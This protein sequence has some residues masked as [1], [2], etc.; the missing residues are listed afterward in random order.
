MQTFGR[1]LTSDA[2]SILQDSWEEAQQKTIRD[3]W[4]RLCPLFL[5]TKITSESRDSV[6]FLE[7]E[8]VENRR[9]L[10]VDRLQ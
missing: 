8:I 9:E 7:N 3:A 6:S 4:K 1:N 5:E 10:I 2:S